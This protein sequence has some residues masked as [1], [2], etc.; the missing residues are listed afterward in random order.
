MDGR[1]A[2]LDENKIQKQ[3]CL[4]V[5]SSHCHY[6]LFFCSSGT[7]FGADVLIIWPEYGPSVELDVHDAGSIKPPT[8]KS[9]TAGPLPKS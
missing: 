7:L 3:R 8:C 4:N 6:L 2:R 9:P 1:D 5:I